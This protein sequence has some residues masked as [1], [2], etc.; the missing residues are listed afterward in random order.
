MAFKSFITYE[1]IQSQNPDTEEELAHDQFET[2]KLYGEIEEIKDPSEARF[3]QFKNFDMLKSPPPNHWFADRRPTKPEIKREWEI[4][5]LF[6][7]NS[8]YVRCYES[9]PDLMR[10]MIVGSENTPYYRGLFIFDIQ[11]PSNHPFQPPEIFYHSYGLDVN[12]NLNRSGKVNLHPLKRGNRCWF[13][14]S[15]SKQFTILGVLRSIGSLVLNDNPYLQEIHHLHI[16]INKN[17]DNNNKNAFMRTCEVMLR[18]LKSPPRDFEDFVIGYF[19]THAH[20]ILLNYKTWMDTE[21]AMESLFF[22][23]VRAFEKNGTYCQ[24]HY[25][26]DSYYLALQ[27]EKSRESSCFTSK[28]LN[29]VRT[30]YK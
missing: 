30:L 18:I 15:N 20:Y 25:N 2:R 19:Q 11:L 24:H 8:I 3:K 23:L 26:Q 12:P 9:R 22:K 16:T 28:V 10:A 5:K 29:T 7:P 17:N 13:G 14:Y 21:E 4:L 27:E 1:R 6:L